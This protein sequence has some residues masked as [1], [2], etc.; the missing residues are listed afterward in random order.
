MKSI[1]CSLMLLTL[2]TSSALAGVVTKC[3]EPEG[4]AFYFSSRL[5][6][7][8]KA[9]WQKDGISRGSYLITRD[10]AGEFDIIFTD[11]MKRTISSKEDGGQIVAVSQSDDHL[12]LVVIYPEMNV[13]TWYFKMDPS[14]FGK[15]TVS[16]ARYGTEALANK[17]SLMT[18]TCS[19]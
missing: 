4:Y 8:D 15:V 2:G 9:G 19:R 16:Q 6:P 11:A 12:V 10:A 18:A 17:H 13:E 7:K 1:L 3:E 14:G 5:V